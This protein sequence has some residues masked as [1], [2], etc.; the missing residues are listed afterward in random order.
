MKMRSLGRLIIVIL[1]LIKFRI[2]INLL[3]SKIKFN[4]EL[5]FFSNIKLL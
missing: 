1:Y 4:K 5:L 3:F 2:N